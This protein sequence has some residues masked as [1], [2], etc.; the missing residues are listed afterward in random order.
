MFVFYANVMNNTAEHAENA[1]MQ[2]YVRARVCVG[3]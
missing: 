2:V 3:V 1:V